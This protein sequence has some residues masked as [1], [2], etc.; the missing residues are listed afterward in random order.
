M[1]KL[2]KYQFTGFVVLGG[3]YFLVYRRFFM[4]KGVY[5][6]VIYNQALRY[7]RNNK[8]ANQVLG[9]GFQVMNCNGKEYPLNKS[10]KFDIVAFGD[11]G[12]GKF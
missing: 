12:R 7:I 10:V 11:S 8:Q 5:G 1:H 9:E 2:R 3:L 6:G 4:S